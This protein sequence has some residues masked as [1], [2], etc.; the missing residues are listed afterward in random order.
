MV[1]LASV[2]VLAAPSCGRPSCTIVYDGSR[3]FY[4]HELAHCNGWDHPPFEVAD[5]PA[6]YVHEFDGDLTVIKCGR[7]HACKSVRKRCLALWEEH[8]VSVDAYRDKPGWSQLRGCS[9]NREY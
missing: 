9:F 7:R 3:H 8:G 4:L 5:P 2:I 1:A 6:A